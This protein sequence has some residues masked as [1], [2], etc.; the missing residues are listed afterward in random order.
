MRFLNARYVYISLFLFFFS[1][2]FQANPQMSS[3]FTIPET[4]LISNSNIVN[5]STVSEINISSSH[6]FSAQAPLQLS[7]TTTEICSDN[8][9][10]HATSAVQESIS[11]AS[12]LS[13]TSTLKMPKN[14]VIMGKC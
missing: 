2:T 7:N 14:C 5:A 9:T 11:L 12:E 10:E 6:N 3:E 4:E 8:S 13:E 1:V